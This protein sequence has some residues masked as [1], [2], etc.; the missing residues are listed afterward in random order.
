MFNRVLLCVA[1]VPEYDESWP[2]TPHVG[3]ASLSE[4][5]SINGIQNGIMDMRLGYSIEDLRRKIINF[6]PDLVGLSLVTP[7]Y[8]K[9]YEIVREIVA[10]N[11]KVVVGGPHASIMGRK[12]LEQCPADFAIQGEGEFPL[13][14]LCQGTAPD[15]INNL[16]FRNNGAI[17]ANPLRPYVRDLDALPFPTYRGFELDLYADRRIPIATSRG[18]P[19]FCNFCAARLVTG[20]RFRARSPESMLNEFR[21]WYNKGYRR[22]DIVDDNFTFDRSRV[23][24][25][26]DLI[27]KH[28]M[29]GISLHCQNG[30]R[31]DR[32]DKD[33]LQRMRR[34]GFDYIAIGVESGNDE[35]LRQIRKGEDLTTIERAIRDACE[36]GLDVGL[37]FI[38]G[39]PKETLSEV[40]DSFRLALKYP[41][42]EVFFYT[43]V[44]FPG[45]ELFDWV[46]R[47]NRMLGDFEERL[48]EF[49]KYRHT[50]FF[51]T[52]EFPYKDR[53]K[54][55][56]RARG[57]ERQ[58]ALRSEE[59]EW[60]RLPL[61]QRIL[62]WIRRRTDPLVDCNMVTSRLLLR[63]RDQR[64]RGLLVRLGRWVAENTIVPRMPGG[65][66]A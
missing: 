30:L 12:V 60:G 25:I 18:C 35:I 28:E 46:M 24:Q 54:A 20:R 8:G 23:V 58:V 14:E 51:A 36:A 6:D 29:S 43:A 16:V 33:L 27:Q 5:L 64:L 40:E 53:T 17:V 10:L 63:T 39:H 13:L 2:H 49:R 22:F 3:I 57:I 37:F 11:R 55:L 62:I 4:I 66:P 38:V 61:F 52:P 21:Y 59:R 48:R 34:V 56:L 19:Y 41:V 1:P 9:Q 26:L 44:P 42:E 15:R 65:N 45:T 32:I 7:E 47:N 31:A 50:P